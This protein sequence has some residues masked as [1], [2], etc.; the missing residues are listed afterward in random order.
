LSIGFTG[1]LAHTGSMA[2]ALTMNARLKALHIPGVLARLHL[3]DRITLTPEGISFDEQRRLTRALLRKGHRVF[4]F[5]YHSP[6]LV[7]GNTP[8]VR[9]EADLRAFLRRIEQYFEFF[10]R[11]IGGRAVTPF[12]IKVLAERCS[13]PPSNARK[14]SS[15]RECIRKTSYPSAL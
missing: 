4:S 12:E 9:D 10:I 14:L 8:Y 15:K 11:E 5:T 2:Y 1:L 13:P 7:P 6:S 3:A